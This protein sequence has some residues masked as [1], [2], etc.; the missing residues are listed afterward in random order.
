MD[1]E[2]QGGPCEPVPFFGFRPPGALLAIDQLNSGDA[3]SCPATQR[4][5]GERVTSCWAGSVAFQ[6]NSSG[7]LAKFAPNVHHPR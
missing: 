5:G 7:S 4:P 1:V 3:G 6:R 2:L